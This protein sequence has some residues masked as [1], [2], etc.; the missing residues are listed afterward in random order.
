M[1]YS[2]FISYNHRDAKFAAWVLKQLEGYRIPPRVRGRETVFGVLGERLPPVFR[3]RE[4]LPTSAD[5]A[6]SVREALDQA[7]TLIVIC[8]PFGAAST[9]VNEEIRYFTRI[10]RRSRI[11]C[12][13]VG[14]VP[15]AS[16]LAGQDPALECFPP[17]LFE[18]GGGEPLAADIRPGQDPRS[19]ARL[20]LIAGMIGVGY[21]ELAQREAQRR[22]RR[23]VLLAGASTTGFLLMAG[24]AGFALVSRAEAVRQRDIARQKSLTAERTVDFVKSLFTISDPSEARGRTITAREILDSGAARIR[25]GLANE[26]TV[27]AELTTTLGEVYAGLGLYR[28]GE[29]LL[30]T[31]AGLSGVAPDT[32]ARQAAAQGEAHARQGRYDEAI[33]AYRRGLAVLAEGAEPVPAVAARLEI[34]LGEALSATDRF[35]EADKALQTALALEKG[36]LSP[37]D[38]GIVRVMEARAL[39]AYFAGRPEDAVPIL[40]EAVAVRRAAHGENHPKVAEGLNLLGVIAY[41]AGDMKLAEARYR[42]VLAIDRVVLGPAHPDLAITTNNLAR[43]VLE[44]RGFVEARALLSEAI[45][46][47]L[48][49]R[50]ESFDDFAFLFANLGLAEQ[51]LGNLDTADRLMQRAWRAAELHQH[52]N[53]G[54]ILADRADIA[55]AQGRVREGLALAKRALP[56]LKTDYPD[57]PWRRA[58]GEAVLASCM[59]A[60]GQAAEARTRLAAAAPVVRAR[61]PKGTLYAERLAG[62]EARMA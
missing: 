19:V 3:D 16:R 6:Q 8:S 60:S 35:E 23:L 15:N 53:R 12:L 30:A 57:D 59:V 27:K 47:S 28:E 32:R 43:V 21:D 55:C 40:E 42:E 46:L 52:R 38:V 54:P 24:L 14:G 7:A 36:R 48:K 10:G 11:Q 18:A 1:R 31:A 33:A 49:Q 25:T 17:A 61:W 9:W 4:E 44:R 37:G 45:A 20:K 5:L 34:G 50:D 22:Q 29:A 58:W 51:G 56:L 26:P 41:E 62:F 13:I 39:N 2:A